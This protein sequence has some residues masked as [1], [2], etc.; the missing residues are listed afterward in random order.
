MLRPRAWV[1]LVIAL[2]LSLGCASAS[3]EGRRVDTGD[4]IIPKPPVLLVYPFALDSD[5]VA[6][7]TLGFSDATHEDRSSENLRIQSELLFQTVSKLNERGINAKSGTD[8]TEIPLNALLVKGQFV[9]IDEGNRA[10]RMI[11]GFGAG[12][13]RLTTQIQVYH[14]TETGLQRVAE[15]EATA[16][17]SRMPGMAVPVVGG[18]TAGRAASAAVISGGMNVMKEATGGLG[19]AAANIAEQIAERAAAYYKERGWL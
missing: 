13:E 10:R 18:A 2:L 9:T 3:V 8:V 16:R 6:V 19:K 12:A 7:D 15:A 17:G 5:D 1:A 14:S 11:I 4:R